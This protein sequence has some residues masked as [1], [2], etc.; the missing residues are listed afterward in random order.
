MEVILNRHTNMEDIDG[1]PS[2]P[3]SSPQAKAAKTKCDL[4][5]LS[6]SAAVV[7]THVHHAKFLGCT[8]YVAVELW[9]WSS[10]SAPVI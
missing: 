3:A 5:G 1:L 4:S 10:L 2:S 6:A 9:P 7:T 8:T